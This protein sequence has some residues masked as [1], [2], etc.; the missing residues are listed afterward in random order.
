MDDPKIIKLREDNKQLRARVAELQE[1]LRYQW[2]ALPS[3]GRQPCLGALCGQDATYRTTIEIGA[4]K[5]LLF[6]C[7]DC[8]VKSAR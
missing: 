1:M 8:V 6:A 5:F 4:L 7:L 3:P 2:E